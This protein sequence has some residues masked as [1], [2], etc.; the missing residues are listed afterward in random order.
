MAGFLDATRMCCFSRPVQSVTATRIFARFLDPNTQVVVYS[1]AIDA[2]EDLAMILPIPVAEGS[3]DDAMKF[4]DLSG[5]EKF[6]DDVESGFPPPPQPVTRSLGIPPPAA[7]AGPPPLVVHTVGKFEASFVPTVKD[8][9]R[10]DER[11]RLPSGVWEKL[12]GYA[13]SGFAVFK[14]KKGEQRVHP[15]A[16]S[17]P[18]A[19]PGKL[20]FPT[21]HIHDGA[22][23]KEADF[24]HVLYCQALRLG[25]GNLHT[26]TESQRPASLFVKTKETKSIVAPD[27]HIY[28]RAMIGNFPNK[29]T[30]LAAA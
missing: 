21:V 12:G 10:L 2:G 7:A 19:T 27:S 20:F 22:V 25:Q 8:F 4:I 1:M 18:T 3:G 26:W 17:F 24:D 5:Y 11:F 23:H 29:D 14:L 9:S 13:R 30:V 16:F 28:R 15:M 6:F